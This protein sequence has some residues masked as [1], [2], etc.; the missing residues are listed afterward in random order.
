MPHSAPEQVQNQSF[1]FIVLFYVGEGIRTLVGTK[2]M[3][4]LQVIISL[5]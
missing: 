3:D 2:P 5:R 4:I 1:V